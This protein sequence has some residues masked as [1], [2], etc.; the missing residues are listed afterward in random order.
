MSRNKFKIETPVKR[1]VEWR[2]KNYWRDQIEVVRMKSDMIPSGTAKY[3][4]NGGRP[5]TTS[6]MTEDV[7]LR[8]EGNTKIKQ[9]EIATE[10]IE[11][12]MLQQDEVAYALIEKIYWVGQKTI[13]A[14]GMEVGLSQSA[15]YAT[16]NRILAAIACEMG[17]PE[18]VTTSKTG[19]KIA[20]T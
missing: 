11:R 16:V 7:V 15:A 2:L 12:V 6:R 17:M 20:I 4:H 19:K 3:S 10:A 13:T 8:V 5:S 9:L 14:A 1:I 18:A